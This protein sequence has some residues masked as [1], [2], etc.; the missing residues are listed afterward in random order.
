[1]PLIGGPV[2]GI[3]GGMAQ[4]R[5]LDRVKEVLEGL[6]E[7]LGDFK[8]KVTDD[9]VRTEDF[10]ELL[11]KTLRAASEERN[12][13]VRALYRRFLAHAITKPG[14]AYDDQIVVLRAV[15]TVRG[16]SLAVL[17]AL[18]QPPSAEAHS[19]LIKAGQT[20][21]KAFKKLV[22]FDRLALRRLSAAAVFL[23]SA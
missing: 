18:L 2:A 14:D 1:V 11:E 23:G 21:G 13:E 20:I 17:R 7:D 6:R 10:A 4:Q 19:G 5:K 9:Y 16:P 3:L 15:E 12:E 8:S 22:T